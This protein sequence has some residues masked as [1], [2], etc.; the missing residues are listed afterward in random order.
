MTDA[1]QV[2]PV[3]TVAARPVSKRVSA[4][5]A[6]A[7]TAA[8]AAEA[9]PTRTHIETAQP[10]EPVVNVQPGTRLTITKDEAANTFVYRSINRD[11]GEVMW[12]YPVEQVLRMAH[13]LRELEGLDAHQIDEKI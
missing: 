9:K 5:V 2:T 7:A 3:S 1:I 8:P 11:T 10:V 4:S 12:Q 6:K 13:R